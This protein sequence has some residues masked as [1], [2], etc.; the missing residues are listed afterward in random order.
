ME[1]TFMT[2]AAPQ[3]SGDDEA[4]EYIITWYAGQIPDDAVSSSYH[5]SVGEWLADRPLQRAEDATGMLKKQ[6]YETYFLPNK[7]AREKVN[8]M[9]KMVLRYVWGLYCDTDD[10]FFE[11]ECQGR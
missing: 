10:Y 9:E 5:P 3:P 1:P 11:Q 8:D 2:L 6:N 7:E 4:R